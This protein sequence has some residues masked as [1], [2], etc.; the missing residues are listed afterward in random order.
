MSNIIL[1]EGLAPG[2]T[3]LRAKM[4]RTAPVFNFHGKVILANNYRV[5]KMHIGLY[6]LPLLK[7]LKR[8]SGKE[9]SSK[10]RPVFAIYLG[11]L[12]TV[13]NEPFGNTPSFYWF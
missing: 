5:Q 3:G 4:L 1:F 11:T 12:I 13:E 6:K 9:L 10:K 8:F 7:M 2:L